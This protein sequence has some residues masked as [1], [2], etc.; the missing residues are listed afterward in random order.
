MLRNKLSFL[1]ASSL[2]LSFA[3]CDDGDDGDDT[4]A[5]ATESGT[6]DAPTTD[7]PTTDT[8]TTD[9]PTTGTPTTDTPTTDDS[10]TTDDTSD[11]SST[12]DDTSTDACEGV[13]CE[14]DQTCLGGICVDDVGET[15]GET[16]GAGECSAAVMFPAAACGEC[17][18]GACCADL[19]GCFGDINEITEPTACGL[20]NDCIGAQL[21]NPASEFQ[22]C[23]APASAADVQACAD[24]AC[25]DTASEAA[26]WLAMNQCIGMNCAAE[27][28]G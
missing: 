25:P 3:A 19:T 27:C 21:G 13:K 28:G 9:T 5:G 2:C 24:A 20:L 23:I 16:E 18:E 4:G 11:D 15:E 26:T 6:T 22:P 10:S 12:T 8:P 7:T 14:A 1:L 17:A